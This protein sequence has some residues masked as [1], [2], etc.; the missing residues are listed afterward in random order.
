[1]TA[2]T[3]QRMTDAPVPLEEHVPTADQFVMLRGDWQMFKAMLALR[4]DHSRPRMAYL[5]GV[6]ELMSPSKP[7]EGIKSAIGDL[8]AAYCQDS[9]IAYSS[10]GSWT[11]ED[12]TEEA[13]LEPDECFLFGSDHAARERADLAVEVIWTRG[14]LKKL[15]IYRRLQVREVWY[16]EK[17]AISVYVL[18]AD[19]YR[20]VE[21]SAV[22]PDLDLALIARLATVVPTSAAVGE[23]REALRQRGGA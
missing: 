10:V 18:G 4:G 8:V 14:G 9:G 15:E 5:D 11:H 23:L 6:V 20:T 2:M 7:H 12:D 1:M 17:E 3:A 16:W 13:G 22:L 19:G 21:R